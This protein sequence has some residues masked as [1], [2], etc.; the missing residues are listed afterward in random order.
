MK[1]FHTGLDVVLNSPSMNIGFKENVALFF[2]DVSMVSDY[3][4]AAENFRKLSGPRRMK[5]IESQ[6]GF[7]L[8]VQDN[9]IES[10]CI[11]YSH[12]NILGYSLYYEVHIPADH[13]V[14]GKDYFL[15]DL[16][17]VGCKTEIYNYTFWLLLDKY[18]VKNTEIIALDRLKL[19]KGIDIEGNILNLEF[20]FHIGRGHLLPARHVF[21]ICEIA[22]LRQKEWAQRKINLTVTKMQ[23]EKRNLLFKDAELLWILP[24]QKL[25]R[26]QSTCTFSST[27][28]SEKT[29]SIKG[30]STAKAF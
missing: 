13:M 15:I 18:I 29:Q 25:A 19:L 6:H 24:S 1:E 9:M 4:S 26:A 27:V 20:D 21:T 28:L 16:Q 23:N 22:P 7:A 5:I 8:G 10:N 2:H 12:F 11:E 30:C 17:N 14:E 3:F